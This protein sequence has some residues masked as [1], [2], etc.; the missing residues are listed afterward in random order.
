MGKMDIKIDADFPYM[1]FTQGRVGHFRLFPL[2]NYKTLNII[3]KFNEY[4]VF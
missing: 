2:K 1:I 3:E 4:D